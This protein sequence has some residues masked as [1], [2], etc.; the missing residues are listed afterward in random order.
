MTV[1]S[2]LLGYSNYLGLDVENIMGAKSGFTDGAG[3]CLASTA[4]YDDV[5]YLLVVIG[6]DVKNKANAVKDT[7]EIYN[8]YRATF[9]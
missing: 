4:N 7:L 1:K 5:N 2:T 3:L 6:S 9:R 8:H